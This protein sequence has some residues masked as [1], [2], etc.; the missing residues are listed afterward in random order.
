[1]TSSLSFSQLAMRA[2]KIAKDTFS[3]NFRRFQCDNGDNRGEGDMRAFRARIFSYSDTD[4]IT[5][6]DMLDFTKASALI[7]A[8]YARSIETET[9]LCL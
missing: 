5:K 7:E 4:P 2:M 8:G 6:I 1:M 3:N 9:V